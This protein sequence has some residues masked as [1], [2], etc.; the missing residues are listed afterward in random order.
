MKYKFKCKKC[1]NV[2][3]FEMKV[4][5]YDDF[6]AKCEECGG[7]MNRVYESPAVGNNKEDSEGSVSQG[8]SQNACSGFCSSC[9]GCS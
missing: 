7:E 4:E 2:Q 8:S 6:E 1:A 5:A 9:M 3:D